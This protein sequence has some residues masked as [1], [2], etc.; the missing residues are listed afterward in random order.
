M[1]G[2]EPYNFK[3]FVAGGGSDLNFVANLTIEQ[4]A[5]DRRSCGDE[6]L[7]NIGFFGADELVLNFYAALHVEDDDAGTVAGAIFRECWLD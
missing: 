5:A 2:D 7:F 6:T 1:N 4:S 3:F